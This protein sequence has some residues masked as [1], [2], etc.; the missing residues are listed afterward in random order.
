[1]GLNDHGRTKTETQVSMSARRCEIFRDVGDGFLRWRFAS[2]REI[3]PGPWRVS[4]SPEV[5]LPRLLEGPDDAFLLPERT[6]PRM[7]AIDRS[8]PVPLDQQ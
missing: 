7:L 3:P 2:E 8:R 5:A 6:C 1:M 4:V